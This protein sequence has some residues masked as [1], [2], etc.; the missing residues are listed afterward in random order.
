MATL[1]VAP[2]V[3]SANKVVVVGTPVSLS[4]MKTVYIIQEVPPEFSNTQASIE[5]NFTAG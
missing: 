5:W 3:D 2:D 4:T 1:I